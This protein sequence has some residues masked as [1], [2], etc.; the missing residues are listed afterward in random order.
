MSQPTIA[1]EVLAL[2]WALKIDT[3]GLAEMP[4]NE[5]HDAVRERVEKVLNEDDHTACQAIAD[6]LNSKVW[7]ARMLEDVAE[8]LREAGYQID[9]SQNDGVLMINIP[10]PVRTY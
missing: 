10:I 7:S 6:L 8:I 1:P 2:L 4:L 3:A 9:A 5:A